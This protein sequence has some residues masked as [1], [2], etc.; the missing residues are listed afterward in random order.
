MVRGTSPMLQSS[1]PGSLICR[2]HQGWKQQLGEPGVALHSGTSF[3]T[4]QRLG[5]IHLGREAE[6]VS[7]LSLMEMLKVFSARKGA[8]VLPALH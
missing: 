3:I 6:R 8:A 5:I 2:L 1:E 4:L 7:E